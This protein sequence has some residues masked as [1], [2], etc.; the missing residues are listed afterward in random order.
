MDNFVYPFTIQKS[1]IIQSATYYLLSTYYVCFDTMEGTQGRAI[2]SQNT[3]RKG[4]EEKGI[5]DKLYQTDPEPCL[6]R[7]H[8]CK[9]KVAEASF[10]LMS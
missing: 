7:N 5:K 9:L 8:V 3:E 6:G 10:A 2:W 4:K 1:W